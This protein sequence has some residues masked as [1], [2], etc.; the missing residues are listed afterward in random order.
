[1]RV[2]QVDLQFRGAQLQPA[3]PTDFGDFVTKSKIAPMVI[4]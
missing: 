2:H 3:M 4:K 1:M